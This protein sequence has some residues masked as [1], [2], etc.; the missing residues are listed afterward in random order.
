M[1]KNTIQ[2]D[3]TEL[4]MTIQHKKLLMKI[5]NKKRIKRIFLKN[6]FTAASKQQI[7][8]FLMEIF[9]LH[10]SWLHRKHCM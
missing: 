2:T 10:F 8:L 7:N 3:N 9:P 1:I 5:Q 6:N 4:N